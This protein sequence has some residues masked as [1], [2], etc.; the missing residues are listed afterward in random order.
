MKIDLVGRLRNIQ[1]PLT[2]VLLPLF[3]AVVNSIHSIEDAKVRDG[4]IDIIIER[5]NIQTGLI[6]DCKIAVIEGFKIIDNGVG[7]TEENFVSFQTS[8]TTFKLSKGS[9]GIG[10][11]LWLKTFNDVKID[12]I[13]QQ[14]NT[15]YQRKFNFNITAPDGICNHSN[16]VT[17]ARERKTTVELSNFAIK[18]SEK[19]PQNAEVIARKIVEHCL[20]YF[21]SSNAPLI[22]VIDGKTTINLNEYFNEEI[23]V[24]STYGKVIFKSSEFEVVGLR[25]YKSENSEHRLHYCAQNREV[26]SEKLNKHISDLVDKK[27]RDEDGHLFTYLAYVSGKYLDERVNAERTDFNISKYSEDIGT[28]FPDEIAMDELR[29]EM[30]NVIKERLKPFLIDVREQKEKTIKRYVT[31]K[32][33]QYRPLLKHHPEI[34]DE[35]APGLSEEQ[36]NLELYMQYSKVEISLKRK[37]LEILASPISDFSKYP[38]YLHK[39]HQFLEQFN[40]FGKSKLAEYIVHR[41]TILELFEKNLM[42]D[43]DGRYKLEKNVHEIIFPLRETSDNIDFERQNLWIIDEKLAYHK[44]LASDKPFNKLNEISVDSNERPDLIVFNN[45]FAFVEGSQPYSSIVIVE[46]KRPM[47]EAYDSD[48]NPIEQVYGYVR[49]IK[50]GSYQ[51]KDGRLVNLARETP[52][53][54]YIICDL[55]PKIKDFAEISDLI[56]SPD[57]QGFFGYNKKLNTY[58]EILSFDKLISDARRR[59]SVLFEKLQLL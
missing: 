4:K 9:K 46:F 3:E 21:L 12:S 49:K 52:F 22:N 10:R 48:E 15:F 41:K 43:E 29:G 20:I 8:D 33:P 56:D 17:P 57:L 27:I 50:S 13:Y 19:C 28:I 42:K 11:F 45:P 51:D 53:Y 47:R 30:C 1:L 40:D 58:V 37:S 34:L 36:L 23:K 26:C 35:I 32:A 31:S 7:F 6:D 2:K 39:Y 59:N 18:Y 24:H 55:T 44:Y 38:D 14:N 54:A 16:T 25:L 5:G